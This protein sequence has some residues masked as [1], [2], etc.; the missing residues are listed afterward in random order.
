MSNQVYRRE[1]HQPSELLLDEA[2]VAVRREYTRVALRKAG[3]LIVDFVRSRLS[4]LNDR[5]RR[6]EAATI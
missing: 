2:G 5:N 3:R 6:A 4:D 1:V